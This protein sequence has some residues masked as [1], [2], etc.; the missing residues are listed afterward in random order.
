MSLSAATLLGLEGLVYAGWAV[1]LTRHADR[2]WL[3]A[4]FVLTFGWAFL[5]N[6]GAILFCL[7]PC[8]ALPPYGDIAH[9]GSLVFGSWGSIVTW[10]TLRRNGGFAW[11]RPA[12]GA[13]VLI[14]VANVIGSALSAE[15]FASQR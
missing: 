6:G 7:P 8:P 12:V 3:S 1:A 5:A 14:V 9:L 15:F 4:I 10:R 2:A 11:G 13:I